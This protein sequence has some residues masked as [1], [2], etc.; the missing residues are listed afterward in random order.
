SLAFPSTPSGQISAAQAVTI[1][2][3]GDL[4]LHV[5]A[6]TAS[7]NF[8][9]TSD[10]LGGVAAQASCAIS[11]E[12]AP[13]QAGALT[14]TL[15]IGDELG[16]KTVA[17]GGAGLQPGVLSASPASLIFP[18]Q[19]PGVASA[20][21]AVTIANRGSEAVS[22]LG[23]QMSGPAAAAYSLGAT[24]CGTV[25]NAGSSCTVQVV[26]TPSA[27]GPIAAI[28]TISS[29]TPGVTAVQVPLN[30]A[31]QISVALT[32][33][34][35]LLSFPAAVAMGQ[36]SSAQTVTITNSS[37][38]AV[39]PVALKVTGPFTV[40]QSACTGSLGPGASCSA[41]VVFTP[42]AAGAATGTLSASSSDVSAPAVTA[43]SGNGF[44]FTV[45]PLGPAS[46]TV[47]SG[48]QADFKL[49]IEPNGAPGNFAFQ[50]GTL[51][52]YALCLFSPATESLGS[53]VQGN[54]EVQIYTGNNSL[55]AETPPLSG[56]GR[57]LLACGFFLLPLGLKQRRKVFLLVLLGVVLI[58]G[59]SSCTSA[60]GGINGKG[61]SGVQNGTNATPPGTYSIPVTVTSTGIARSI[62]LTLTVD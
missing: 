51:P 23:I 12:F 58:A 48:Q 3:T 47:S 44:D 45:A 24:T 5:T 30:G 27:A 22:G 28:L 39:A 35:A 50:C 16:T 60:I 57:W 20:P 25:L 52:S 61:G 38:F 32:A 21:Q 4:P 7:T 55:T 33:A 46:A 37:S 26:F 10:C 53:G 62:T 59:V 15:T 42:A 49:A 8:Q 41:S 1:S 14:G 36:A 40:P 2:N 13:A 18:Q 31:G 34:P 11:V 29:S 56:A 19:Q 9:Q 6:I 17:L 43:L 54:I